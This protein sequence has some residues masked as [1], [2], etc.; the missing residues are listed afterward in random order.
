MFVTLLLQ[1]VI[2]DVYYVSGFKTVKLSLESNWY[3]MNLEE[4]RTL[5]ALEVGEMFHVWLY[6]LVVMCIGE[7][8]WMMCVCE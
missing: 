5:H 3:H 1:N 2:V 4:S 8:W 6:E 7:I